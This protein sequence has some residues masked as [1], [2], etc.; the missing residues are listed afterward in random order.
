MYTSVL[1]LR[2]LPGRHRLHAHHASR[3][4]CAT[5]ASPRSTARPAPAPRQRRAEVFERAIDRGEVRADI[6][7]S[8]AVQF[9]G[10]MI[11]MRAITGQDMP[12]LEELDELVDFVLHGISA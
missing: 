12:G 3:S 4:R 8:A 2:E 6:P 10:G 11:A 9:L 5:S 1:T 7:M